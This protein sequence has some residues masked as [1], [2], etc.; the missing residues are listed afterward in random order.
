MRVSKRSRLLRNIC[1]DNIYEMNEVKPDNASYSNEGA[2][3]FTKTG[4]VRLT[5]YVLLSVT[6]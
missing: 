5:V 2:S 3:S 1:I 6:K 4:L